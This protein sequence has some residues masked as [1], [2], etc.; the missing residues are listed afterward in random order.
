MAGTKDNYFL[1]GYSVRSLF[2]LPQTTIRP[3][4]DEGLRSTIDRTRTRPSSASGVWPRRLSPF[5]LV[6]KSIQL[7]PCFNDGGMTPYKNINIPVI[8][9]L[10]HSPFRIPV[11]PTGPSVHLSGY[12]SSSGGPSCAI[13]AYGGPVIR[14]IL[15]PPCRP[16]ILL[17]LA[18]IAK[19]SRRATSSLAI[20]TGGLRCMCVDPVPSLLRDTMTYVSGM[21]TNHHNIN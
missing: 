8:F 16:P 6:S 14:T 15:D 18:C 20:P 1:R 13:R 9:Q 21:L 4:T 7:T 19:Y 5:N 10:R 3:T 12:F 2:N 17:H 11:L